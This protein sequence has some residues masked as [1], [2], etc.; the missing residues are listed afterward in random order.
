MLTYSHLDLIFAALSNPTRRFLFEK[1]CIEEEE[2]VTALTEPLPVSRPAVLQH[3]AVLE[4]SGLIHTEKRDR[5]RWCCIEPQALDLLE[6]WLHQ[7]RV[8]FERRRMRG[9]A[10]PRAIDPEI[11]QLLRS[12]FGSLK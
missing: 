6:Q 8:Y 11:A 2:T 9:R 5:V 7:Y 4:K 12:P 10:L 3:L 1:L